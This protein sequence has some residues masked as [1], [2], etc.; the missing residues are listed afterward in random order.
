MKN[1]IH[2]IVFRPSEI[3]LYYNGSHTWAMK[4]SQIHKQGFVRILTY[5]LPD[6]RRIDDL[7]KR[8]PDNISLICH[9]KFKQQAL[10]L[11]INFPNI[12]IAINETLHS[13]IVLIEPDTIFV[14]SANFGYSSWHET[15]V[16][17]R[18]KIAYDAYVLNSFQPLWESSQIL[19]P[20]I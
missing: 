19:H 17:I 15:T 6:L 13:K 1:D 12:N 18:S 11:A 7:L 14:T 16:G 8:R 20:S 10:Q 3:K 4:L 9:S 5:S 2:G